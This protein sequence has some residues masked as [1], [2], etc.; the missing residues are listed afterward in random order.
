MKK[1]AQKL[2]NIKTFVELNLVITN[3]LFYLYSGIMFSREVRKI[4]KFPCHQNGSYLNFGFCVKS[5]ESQFSSSSHV[6]G[7]LR[8]NVDEIMRSN[9]RFFKKC[10]V[11]NEHGVHVG[12]VSLRI[13]VTD[14]CAEGLCYLNHACNFSLL[15]TKIYFN[16]DKIPAINRRPD[17]RPKTKDFTAQH[18]Y[19][20]TSHPSTSN[21]D[22]ENH[23]DRNFEHKNMQ[24]DDN[25]MRT[26]G[27]MRKESSNDDHRDTEMIDVEEIKANNRN[28]KVYKGVLFIECLRSVKDNSQCSSDYFITY[29]GFWNDCQEMTDVSISNQFNYLKVI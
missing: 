24:T 14:D 11:I 29:E 25:E 12:S 5:V 1:K 28:M 16:L 26:K 10:S 21:D 22:C 23:R 9:C 20:V 3:Y 8:V 27:S 4:I 15:I 13:E 18:S 6:I 17:C 2:A 19:N 7:Y